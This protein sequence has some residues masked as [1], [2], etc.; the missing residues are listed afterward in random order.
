M[1][2][3][4][5][6]RIVKVGVNSLISSVRCGTVPDHYSRCGG[7]QHEAG[8]RL[9]LP[10]LKASPS[11]SLCISFSPTQNRFF[12]G[13]FQPFQLLSVSAL[14]PQRGRNSSVFPP[15]QGLQRCCFLIRMVFTVSE[16]AHWWRA[17]V[18]PSIPA[19]ALQ[20]RLTPTSARLHG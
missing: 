3:K 10:S 11:P 9:V 8:I 4:Q 6:I 5:S 1:Y 15:T 7:V 19:E 12:I 18:Q 20:G 16:S 13:N 2:L 17:P 14:S